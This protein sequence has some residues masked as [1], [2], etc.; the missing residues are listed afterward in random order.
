MLICICYLIS[1]SKY[2]RTLQTLALKTQ[3]DLLMKEEPLVWPPSVSS[4][5]S[6]HTREIWMKNSL[7]SSNPNPSCLRAWSHELRW[8]IEQIN[9]RLTKMMK[10]FVYLNIVWS[11]SQNCECVVKLQKYWNHRETSSTSLNSRWTE[12]SGDPWIKELSW[13]NGWTSLKK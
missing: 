10:Y 4:S 7:I 3:S 2:S 6:D 8:W 5:V 13:R 11:S 1:S 9:I 12:E